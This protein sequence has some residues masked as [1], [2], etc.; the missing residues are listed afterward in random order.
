MRAAA[1]INRLRGTEVS[2]I[3]ALASRRASARGYLHIGSRPAVFV[4]LANRAQRDC[5]AARRWRA[6]AA[7]FWLAQ[8]TFA[9]Y[10][11]CSSAA[12]AWFSD[13]R[14]ARSARAPGTFVIR[15]G[16]RP[17]GSKKSQLRR[18][19][20]AWRRAVR[21]MN[22][23]HARLQLIDS[24]NG[25]GNGTA[26]GPSSAWRSRSRFGRY[27]DALHARSPRHA[28]R[29]DLPAVGALA[30]SG[31]TAHGGSV[32]VTLSADSARS[33]WWVEFGP[34][35]DYGQTTA[36]VAL[37]AASAPRAATANLGALAAGTTYHARVVAASPAGVVASPDAVFTTPAEVVASPVPVVAPPASASKPG[38]VDK[39]LVFVEENHS[40]DQMKA[41]MPYLYSQ[42]QQYGY[43]TT[44]T[45]LTHPSLP[46][47]LGM[48]FGSTFGV[49]DDAAPSSHPQLAPDVF[50]GAVQAGRT[51]RSYQESMTGNCA[52]TSQGSYA[53]KHNPWAYASTPA[54]R[55][56]CSAGDVPLGSTTAGFL[57]DDIVNGALPNVGEVTPN[58]ANDGHDG[59]LA[60]A[61]AWLQAWLTLLYAGPDWKSGHLA[62]I[63]TADEDAN[64]QGNQVLT[65]VIHPSQTGHVVT[66]ALTHYSLTQLLSEVGHSN[67]VGSGCV[68][69]S[70]AAAFGFTV[71]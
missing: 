47:Y 24:L 46:N 28:R 9:G 29:A 55:A 26:I 4:A 38:A 51:A 15:P 25:W 57:H 48:A 33:R 6:A 71:A 35:A 62:I 34:T 44:Y 13:H 45:A 20:A 54:G 66:S 1:L 43:A 37:P 42:A 7:G 49:T 8:A 10:E 59:S 11:R 2:Q 5:A 17:K 60:T 14:R 65:T 12:N 67:C 22:A 16:F 21:R 19:L 32:V 63:V 23:S 68:A 56:A 61:D 52:L 64:N 3:K 40:F 69:P 31:V 30:P 41:G 36:P 18:S 50:T 70:F 39:V 27:L 58:L 53:V